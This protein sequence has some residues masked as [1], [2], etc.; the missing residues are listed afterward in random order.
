MAEMW[1]SVA[2][3]KSMLCCLLTAFSKGAR[4]CGCVDVDDNMG[5]GAHVWARLGI[6]LEILVKNHFMKS[7]PACPTSPHFCARS[8]N[9]TSFPFHR[10]PPVLPVTA[11]RQR[12]LA[13]L[14]EKYFQIL[15]G[16]RMQP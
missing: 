2:G 11:H 5:I 3:I 1:A 4:P 8:I 7:G 15:K 12:I 9:P 10:I 16:G 6:S 14:A 13:G